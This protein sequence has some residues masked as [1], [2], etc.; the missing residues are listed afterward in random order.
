[1][2][3]AY[4]PAGPGRVYWRV[5]QFMF[6]FFTN[7]PTGVLGNQI[8]TQAWV[9]MDD[10]HTLSFRFG[11]LTPD[12]DSR[13]DTD[14]DASSAFRALRARA[15]S[16][17][18]RRPN[19]ADWYG[20]FRTETDAANDYRIDRKLQRSETFTG[21]EDLNA[22]D[23]AVTESMGPIYDRSQEHLGTTDAMLIRVRRRLINAARDLVNKD[24]VPP[25]V[26]NPTVYG[27]R[28][29]GILLP[30]GADWMEAFNRLGQAY[31]DHPELDLTPERF[32]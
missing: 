13:S 21:M 10:Y 2:Y 14:G 29:G 9:P 26:D 19:T 17:P 7:I 8:L 6:P 31:Q 4:R 11:A 24:L 16:V 3:G 28:S 23:Q 27:I 22:E 25:G 12:E 30:E 5:G 1:M 18:A 32:F 15:R 20:R